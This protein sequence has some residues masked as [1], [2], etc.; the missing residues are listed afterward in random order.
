MGYARDNQRERV[1]KAERATFPM[2]WDMG[3]KGAGLYEQFVLETKAEATRFVR[4]VCSSKLYRE[5]TPKIQ[6]FYERMKK[7]DKPR[8]AAARND[9]R[10]VDARGKRSY[11]REG[12]WIRREWGGKSYLH[13]AIHI[14]ALGLKSKHVLLHELCHWAGTDPAGHGPQFAFA[15]EAMTRKLWG[16]VLADTLMANYAKFG[17]ESAW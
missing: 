3:G 13:P 17:V 2:Y 1:Y 12:E 7:D 11:M 10:I 15:L 8:F 6:G 5:M 14:T 4:D 9:V 16:D